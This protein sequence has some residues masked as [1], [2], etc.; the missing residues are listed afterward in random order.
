MEC[1]GISWYKKVTIVLI[2]KA[3]FLTTLMITLQFASLC[4]ETHT[5][6]YV[7]YSNNKR[8]LESVVFFK[9]YQNR[10]IEPL[11][12]FY[13]LHLIESFYCEQNKVAKMKKEV[14]KISV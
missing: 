14:K 4:F 7:N 10:F 2:T 13:F 3:A 1:V 9:S 11:L 5:Y 12:L 8:D 6:Y